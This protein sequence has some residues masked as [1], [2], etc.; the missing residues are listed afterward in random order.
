MN[1]PTV[2]A[3]DG[4]VGDEYDKA[5]FTAKYRILPVFRPGA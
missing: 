5:S 2:V 1:G 4:E 3:C